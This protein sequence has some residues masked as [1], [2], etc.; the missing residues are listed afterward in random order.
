MGE[1]SRFIEK[2]RMIIF[3]L[4]MMWNTGNWDYEYSVELFIKGLEYLKKGI[5]SRDKFESTE[6][7]VREIDTFINMYREYEKDS[8]FKDYVKVHKGT[9]DEEVRLKAYEEYNYLVELEKE[10]VFNYLRDHLENWW[11]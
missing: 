9:K 4:P 5:L 3:F 7:T 8:H 11:D 1:I 2:V 6:K 10:E